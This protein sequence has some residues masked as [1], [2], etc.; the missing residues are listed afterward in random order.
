M[1]FSQE[2]DEEAEHRLFASDSEGEAAD[3]VISTLT[4]EEVQ[5]LRASLRVENAEL[6]VC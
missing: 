4:A 1:I 3:G 5:A 6:R 2:L